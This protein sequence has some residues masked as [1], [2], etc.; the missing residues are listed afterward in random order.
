[1]LPFHARFIDTGLSDVSIILVCG[2]I[3]VAGSWLEEVMDNEFCAEPTL[4]ELFGDA[5]MRLLMQ[6]DGVT[7]SD[8]R[9]LLGKLE[10]ERAVALGGSKRGA[11]RCQRCSPPDASKGDDRKQ[12]GSCGSTDHFKNVVMESRGFC[13]W[14]RP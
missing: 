10:D 12:R 3:A 9:A 13:R 5:A 4:D 1:M 2:L 6:R 8:I 11:R 14:V 7:E